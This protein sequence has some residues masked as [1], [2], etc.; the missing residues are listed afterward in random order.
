MT[1]S[2]TDVQRKRRMSATSENHEVRLEAFHELCVRAEFRTEEWRELLNSIEES[3]FNE[4]GRLIGR[5]DLALNHAGAS[6]QYTMAFQESEYSFPLFLAFEG[7]EVDVL[8]CP[9]EDLPLHI[10]N[11]ATEPLAAWRL[12]RGR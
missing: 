6:N 9:I 3:G 8:F 11:K 10:G 1:L 5:L 7:P 12:M 4:N 2:R